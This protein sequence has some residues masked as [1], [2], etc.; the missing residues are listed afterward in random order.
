MSSDTHEHTNRCWWNLDEA[1]WICPAD[2]SSEGA[3]VD[4]RDMIVV[5]TALLREFRLAPAAVTHTAPGNR[6]RAQ[7][8][9][10]HL[11]FL[12]DMLHHHHSGEDE[13][14]WPKLRARAAESAHELIGEMESQHAHIDGAL[15]RVRQLRDA[16]RANPSVTLRTELAAAL[17]ALHAALSEHLDLEERALLPLAA[18]LL[19]PDEWHAI[20]ERA[21]AA[22]RKPELALSF[23]MFSYEGD[24]AVLRDM[25]ATAPPP[26]RLLLPHIAPRLYAHRAKAIHGTARP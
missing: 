13:L 4:V 17:T 8:V 26:V 14:L 6:K 2:M 18:S 11:R 15:S 20:G 9:A 5:H 16:W 22:M 25:L 23:G 24:R 19:T 10:G 7:A 1:R 12:C 21:V 3:L